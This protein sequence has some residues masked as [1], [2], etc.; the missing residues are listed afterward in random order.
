[1]QEGL[2]R[3]LGGEVSMNGVLRPVISAN[4]ATATV[5][6]GV[7]DSRNAELL[8]AFLPALAQGRVQVETGFIHKD[9]LGIGCE[10]PFFSSSSRV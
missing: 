10:R 5:G 9:E 3:Q 6:L 8:P 1:M 4:D 7:A 2:A